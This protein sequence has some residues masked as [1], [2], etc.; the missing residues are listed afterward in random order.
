MNNSI[1]FFVRGASWCFFLISWVGALLE[2]QEQEI[3]HGLLYEH[4]V[5]DTHQSIHILKV[6]PSVCTI[7][8]ARAL[9]D[10]IGREAVTSLCTR[11]GAV[12]AINGG[13]FQM[14]GTLDG[15]PMGILK[16]Q[17][18][19]FSLPYKP[20][21]AIGWNQKT[22]SVAIDQLQASCTVS[23]NGVTL[24]I[25]GIN[26]QRKSGETVVFTPSFHRTTLTPP[27]GI[28]IVIENEKVTHVYYNEG[29]HSIPSHGWIL[30]I[31]K[32]SL[33]IPIKPADKALLHFSIQPQTSHTQPKDWENMEYIVGGAP[34]LLR[35]G[36]IVHD[37]S[38]E[39]IVES[40]LQKPHART[41]IALVPKGFFM[42][43]VVD[44]DES[45]EGMT[46]QQLAQLL[47]DQGCTEALNV[48]GGGSAS[49]VIDGQLM[50][51]PRG[52]DNEPQGVKTE[53]RVS[54]AILISSPIEPHES[55]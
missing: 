7:A 24:P 23:I 38:S 45:S 55:S 21:G 20:R 26:R 13:F 16:I 17:N 53:R 41:A 25:D 19:W 54:D 30:S 29:N 18:Q 14:G 8:I 50:N 5:T 3:R 10:G 51:N 11:H 1:Y 33:P 2:A 46:I 42:F 27:R 4:L 22:A 31:D 37:V 48:D 44:K 28:E 34:V 36:Q 40:F 47:L 35:D 52:A 6:D 12:A 32:H 9:D 43:V 49:L 15:L 39:K